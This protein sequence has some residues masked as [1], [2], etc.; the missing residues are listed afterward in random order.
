ML[1]VCFIKVRYLRSQNE[2]EP[3]WEQG[4]SDV[5]HSAAIL[6]DVLCSSICP[7]D[8]DNYRL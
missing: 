8:P 7:P 5:C 4:Q 1:I 3:H 2:S 6:S